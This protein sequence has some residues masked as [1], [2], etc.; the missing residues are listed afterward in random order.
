MDNRYE[1]VTQADF[2][3]LGKVRVEW[4]EHLVNANIKLLFDTKKKI[5]EKKIVLAKIYKP[6]DLI[7]HY[8]AEDGVSYIIILD[9]VAWEVAPEID[10][11]RLL[12][13]ELRHAFISESGKF[14]L[15]GHDFEDFYPEAKLNSDDP[16]WARR[17]STLT[18]AIY[19]QREEQ[20]KQAK[21][22]GRKPGRPKRGDAQAKMFS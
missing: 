20:A 15:V 7:N 8:I 9:K 17:I 13:H 19:A 4:F 12:R 3:V 1:D 21:K 2:D 6:N 10:K 14:E 18:S 11:V 22:S 5:S 16:D